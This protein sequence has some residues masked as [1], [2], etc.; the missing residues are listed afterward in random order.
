MSVIT[1]QTRR[2]EVWKDI[3]G[4]ESIYQVSNFGRIKSLYYTNNKTKKKYRRDKI[5][6]QQQTKQGYMTIR[7]SKD[8][9]DKTYSVHRI[10]AKTFILN[11]NNKDEVNHVDGH[12]ENNCVS[13]LEWVTRKENQLHAYRNGLQ[14]QTPRMREHSI[15]L[16]KL[17]GKINGAKTGKEN[18]KKAIESRKLKINQYSRVGQ[19]IKT[20]ESISEAARN[21]GTYKSNICSCI[22]GRIGSAGGYKWEIA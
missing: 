8:G 12:K 20:W 19:Y 15:E 16:G 3:E 10:V 2:K 21:T 22:K 11:P 4:Y 17:Y 7:L 1:M 5:L 18:I 9:I 6:K 13:N 14:R